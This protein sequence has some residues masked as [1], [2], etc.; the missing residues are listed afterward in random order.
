MK[1]KEFSEKAGFESD[2]RLHANQAFNQIGKGKDGRVGS[3]FH[4]FESAVALGEV[5]QVPVIPGLQMALIDF[6]EIE[7]ALEGMV[8]VAQV[9]HGNYYVISRNFCQGS[10]HLFWIFDMFQDVETGYNIEGF[11]LELGQ[12]ISRVQLAGGPEARG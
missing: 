5:Q 1:G 4:E 2:Q 3:P 9:G 11:H 10:Q 8:Q 7:F 12:G 6:A